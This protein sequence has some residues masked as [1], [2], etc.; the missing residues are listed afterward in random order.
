M[1]S[2]SIDQ[3]IHNLDGIASDG[4]DPW[5][6]IL[7]IL[8]GGWAVDDKDAKRWRPPPKNLL[9]FV[10]STF[11]D[12]HL[13]RDILTEQ[14]LP[15]LQAKAQ[16]YGMLVTLTDMRYGVIEANQ[17]NHRVWEYCKAELVRCHRDSA[18][19][20]FLSLQGSK[21]GYR[22]IPRTIDQDSFEQRLS[23][24]ANEFPSALEILRRWYF[25][26][27]NALPRL[28]TLK[29]IASAAEDKLF[30]RDFPVLH[31]TLSEI[32]FEPD[33]NSLLVGQSITEWETRFSMQLNL[34]GP[35]HTS[36]IKKVVWMERIFPSSE[37]NETMDPK[38]QC[39]DVY[40]DGN[41]EESHRSLISYMEEQFP[42]RMQVYCPSVS[43]YL[44]YINESS[45]QRTL[46]V[47]TDLEAYAKEWSEK[48][49]KVME[50]DLDTAINRRNIWKSVPGVDHIE[51][52]LHHGEWAA[53]KSENFVGRE[54]LVAELLDAISMSDM[55][56]TQSKS[57]T[58]AVIGSSGCGKTALMAK[59]AQLAYM[60]EVSIGTADEPASSAHSNRRRFH[61]SPNVVPS[62]MAASTMNLLLPPQSSIIGLTAVQPRPVIIRFCG[63]S[64]DSSDA[65][66]LVRS[67]CLQL[68]L[69]FCQ[70]NDWHFATSVTD[71]LAAV[72][73]FHHL[74]QVHPI[75]LFIDSLDQLSDAYQGRSRLSFLSNLQPHP[76]TR[77][78]VS[79]LPDEL[80]P[81]TREWIYC[82]QCE[83]RLREWQIPILEVR[84]LGIEI[85]PIRREEAMRRARSD[86]SH[87]ESVLFADIP[88]VPDEDED[89]ENPEWDSDEYENMLAIILREKYRRQCS[90]Q[91]TLYVL[92]QAAEEPS[93]LYLQLACRIISNW[94]SSDVGVELA[95]GVTALIHQI[96]GGLEAE[97]GVVVTRAALGFLTFARSGVT[98][99]EMQNLLTLHQGV[100]EEVDAFHTMRRPRLPFHVWARLRSALEGLI[101][102]KQDGC[103]RW[104]HRQLQETAERRYSI[105]DTNSRYNFNFLTE[106]PAAVPERVSANRER[107][108]LHFTMARFFG[109]AVG[110]EERMLKLIAEQPLLW[111]HSTDTS[112]SPDVDSNS[113]DSSR[114]GDSSSSPPFPPVAGTRPAYASVWT[115]TDEWRI[116]R[117]RCVESSYH[118]ASCVAWVLKNHPDAVE[119]KHFVESMIE[120]LCHPAYV[121][122]CSKT[123]H[124][125]PFLQDLRN[126]RA[127]LEPFKQIAANVRIRLDQYIRW[128]R[129]HIG[130]LVKNPETQIPYTL[131][132]MAE[133]YTELGVDYEQLLHQRNAWV[134]STNAPSTET[135]DS[136]II[137]EMKTDA[138]PTESTALRTVTND[139]GKQW[140]FP[141]MWKVERSATTAR[142]EMTLSGC[143]AHIMAITASPTAPQVAVSYQS[144]MIEIWD[145]EVGTNTLVMEGASSLHSTWLAYTANGR[146]LVSMVIGWFKMGIVEVWDAKIGY[147]LLYHQDIR[148]SGG[149]LCNPDLNHAFVGCNEGTVEMWSLRTAVCKLKLQEP[150]PATSSPVTSL[151]GFELPSKTTAH[152]SS[153][154][155]SR[156]S[157]RTTMSN[158]E[159]DVSVPHEQRRDFLVAVGFEDGHI[160]LWNTSLVTPLSRLTSYDTYPVRVLHFSHGGRRLTSSSTPSTASLPWTDQTTSLS[161]IRSWTIQPEPVSVSRSQSHDLD[162]FGATAVVVDEDDDTSNST[163]HG[164]YIDSW[165]KPKRQHEI[166]VQGTCISLTYS[167]TPRDRILV[168]LENDQ[169]VCR[170][171]NSCETVASVTAVR[172]VNLLCGGVSNGAY[173]TTTDDG[174]QIH[175]WSPDIH[176]D[177]DDRF[178]TPGR[179]PPFTRSLSRTWSSISAFQSSALLPRT[180]SSFRLQQQRTLTHRKASSERL[181][182]LASDKSLPRLSSERLMMLSRM[183]SEKSLPRLSSER[184]L[185]RYGSLIGSFYRNGGGGAAGM[186]DLTALDTF[187]IP[188][189][190]DKDGGSLEYIS[191]SDDEDDGF[192]ASPV[193]DAP[194]TNGSGTGS[195]GGK[196]GASL[197]MTPAAMGNR[198]RSLR[199]LKSAPSL[200]KLSF[201][202]SHQA[203]NR[204]QLMQSS[205]ETSGNTYGI[206][207]VISDLAGDFSSSNASLVDPRESPSAGHAD[208]GI[209]EDDEA[210][211]QETDDR[212]DA[213]CVHPD[214][215]YVAVARHRDNHITLWSLDG[216]L[217]IDVLPDHLNA[218]STDVLTPA[219][220]DDLMEIARTSDLLRVIY[221]RFLR[222]GQRLLIGLHCGLFVIWDVS[223]RRFVCA[224]RFR[225]MCNP[226]FIVVSPDDRHL[227][228]NFYAIW[229][230][231]T[232]AIVHRPPSSLEYKVSVFDSA[233]NQALLICAKE[234]GSL[235][236]YDARQE[237][238]LLDLTAADS[239]SEL[240]TSEVTEAPAG[241]LDGL[242]VSKAT[243]VE[244][245]LETVPAALVAL[246]A[247]AML[248]PI[249]ASSRRRFN[250]PPI[251][252]HPTE[253]HETTMELPQR[254][255]RSDRVVKTIDIFDHFGVREIVH[256][257]FAPHG[258][259]VALLSNMKDIWLAVTPTMDIV[260]HVRLVDF[261][262]EVYFTLDSRHV[263]ATY[264]HVGKI[265]GFEVAASSSVQTAAAV[266]MGTAAASATPRGSTPPTLT[267]AM[268][269]P[270]PGTTS[271]AA[272]AFFA[273]SPRNANGHSH[274]DAAAHPLLSMT[275]SWHSASPRHHDLW[276]RHPRTVITTQPAWELA[277]PQSMGQQHNTVQ[278][279]LTLSTQHLLLITVTEEVLV[280]DLYG[281]LCE[282][283]PSLDGD[284]HRDDDGD[285]DV[286]GDDDGSSVASSI[287][288]AVHTPS[289]LSFYHPT[290]PAALAA[291]TSPTAALSRTS[292]GATAPS[293]VS[294]PRATPT[295]HQQQQRQQHQRSFPAFPLT[296]SLSVPLST[297]SPSTGSL[298]RAA[299]SDTIGQRPPHPPT[300]ALALPPPPSASPASSTPPV[301]QQQR[302]HAISHHGAAL[303]PSASVTA[304]SSLAS[305]SMDSADWAAARMASLRPPLPL[306]MGAGQATMAHGSRISMFSGSSGSS[307]D[308]APRTVAPRLLA[309][310][311]LLSRGELRA[312]SLSS[313]LELF[314]CATTGQAARIFG[315]D[316][317]G[318]V[319]SS[320]PGDHRHGVTSPPA[321]AAGSS[322]LPRRHQV[323]P[324]AEQEREFLRQRGDLLSF[325]RR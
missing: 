32:S 33:D 43:S 40:G 218:T 232:G 46:K 119:A 248:Q 170:D 257:A 268:S 299:S 76:D 4:L 205:R 253:A 185:H 240:A 222:Q 101:V 271:S 190:R 313:N 141:V 276:R 167:V 195:D 270:S 289:S 261:A 11:T 16:K 153:V 77:I 150:S 172:Q 173:V 5:E 254:R 88:H 108:E 194:S 92:R 82:Y 314:Y 70:P 180:N 104:Y 98:D 295:H 324:W 41:V 233:G 91:Q 243:P 2:Q 302:R 107:L 162:D 57:L 200:H 202:N 121:C 99:N 97:Y 161:V 266:R 120:D 166:T 8:E 304:A 256:A 38:R 259:T 9:I 147:R 181:V 67:I 260:Q 139:H 115:S 45:H 234:T 122:A 12:S 284:T 213:L 90:A 227:V 94:T 83:S 13:E 138:F 287:A 209:T 26:D 217:L 134:Q 215:K 149:L 133:E 244:A 130:V 241:T 118:L 210:V 36:E 84:K 159:D 163:T 144:G 265:H 177:F 272:G 39:S 14:I 199:N 146:K 160:T 27:Y 69:V 37:L 142:P 293:M 129:M 74:L 247:A 221:L 201:F 303:P 285:D 236:V 51:E 263:M 235:I 212:I 140:V 105:A 113:F 245:A 179:V 60:R 103:L 187:T 123:G 242:E 110:Q 58:C 325:Y 169:I 318:L 63:T 35:M 48:L 6:E 323:W 216:R 136:G 251:H 64:P 262:V 311:P 25:L 112:S 75:I 189:V 204:S 192:P 317:L 175:V 30:W 258:S 301:H 155:L 44:D 214:G 31:Q 237:L 238:V 230:M 73:H 191:S 264:S 154:M 111:Q 81:I 55:Y 269:F 34:S 114:H 109:N 315:L 24:I 286:D 176:L 267:T 273:A 171:G 307:G 137:P 65:F 321:G 29:Y 288:G 312:V 226:R 308:D 54:K 56:L 225:E 116:N 249:S 319:I 168:T 22:P 50:D 132:E 124:L 197:A 300:V 19:L 89:G 131:S 87:S 23:M 219:M 20:F 42:I 79:T 145:V 305:R 174:Q 211:M 93:V 278:K 282:A 320:S 47:P 151:A 100:I 1:Q 290:N 68:S 126:L 117:R 246:E 10:S 78:I 61:L 298:S 255:H 3:D 28:Y 164:I 49:R 52:M 239:T 125:V 62:N 224:Q 281:D 157:S 231:E 277:L 184:S 296:A 80:D 72:Q 207:T 127:E 15:S 279:I 156:H 316:V 206:D 208:G 297:T 53:L 220:V 85:V 309:R 196:V 250:I 17:R 198:S 183:P 143:K 135:V 229:D 148:L 158:E 193:I 292:S 165:K 252:I 71:Y 280:Y 274:S 306:A 152:A 18:G 102:E 294:S 59:V 275:V 203:H 182:R 66:S 128:I 322:P 188:E 7:P 178:R 86:A 310:V 291:V 223:E 95:S 21:Y 228:P 283:S 96:F 106:P 186:G